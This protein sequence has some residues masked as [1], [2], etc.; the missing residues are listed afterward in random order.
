MI[1]NSFISGM[2]DDCR[3]SSYGKG[4]SGVFMIA[5][6]QSIKAQP[7]IT[8]TDLKQKIVSEQGLRHILGAF[9]AETAYM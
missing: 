3:K 2:G 1:P 6:K 5:S 8:A 7:K 4:G 9:V